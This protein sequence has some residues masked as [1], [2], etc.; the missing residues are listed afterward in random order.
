MNLNQ[1]LERALLAGEPVEVEIAGTACVI[2]ST[3]TYRRITEGELTPRD[4]YAAVLKAIDADDENPDQYLE[5][6]NVE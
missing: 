1:E 6:L 4:T 5:Y 3:Q 2:L